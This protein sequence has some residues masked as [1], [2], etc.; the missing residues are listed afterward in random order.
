[1]KKTIDTQMTPGTLQKEVTV[2]DSWFKQ[3]WTHFAYFTG[4]REQSHKP[5]VV[6]CSKG[7]LFPISETEQ[8]WHNCIILCFACNRLLSYGVNDFYG[9][10]I[11]FHLIFRNAKQ[12]INNVAF[13]MAS[14][15]I[16]WT[17]QRLVSVLTNKSSLTGAVVKLSSL[18]PS[19]QFHDTFKSH[20][21]FCD[22]C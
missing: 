3:T 11:R 14:K 2:K 19:N 20:N 13:Y 9:F 6:Y 22:L 17:L 5:T 21:L 1:M 10:I 8:A 12:C 16:Y 7:I 18:I 4:L 15:N